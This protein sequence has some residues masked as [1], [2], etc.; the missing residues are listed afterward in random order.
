MAKPNNASPNL[1]LFDC[2]A[3]A[4]VSKSPPI[5]PI[6]STEALLDE[7]D[8]CGVDE[9]LVHSE[10]AEG[11]SPLVTNPEIKA[12]CAPSSR[13]HPA[14]HILPAQTG[15]MPPEELRRQMQDAGVKMLAARPDEHRYL[16]NGITFGPLFEMIIECRIPLFLASN[17]QR[18]TDLLSEF[19]KLRVIVTDLGWWG[20]DRYIR[21]LLERFEGFQIETSSFELDGGIP[22]LVEKYGATRILFGSA[23]HRRAMGG[24]SLLLRNLDISAK[25]KELIAH[26]NLE[27]LLEESKP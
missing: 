21:P 4:G 5:D 10:A 23:C 9:A 20:S 22:A 16:L 6:L 11:S 18:V 14:W 27:R 13:L 19:P 3:R 1:R 26:G 15:E 8:L 17:W 24:A 7:M 12:F 2:Y 25:D